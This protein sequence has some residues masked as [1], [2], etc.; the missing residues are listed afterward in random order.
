MGDTILVD[1]VALI[2]LVLGI[3]ILCKQWFSPAWWGP[4]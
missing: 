2:A 1:V 3:Y 4:K